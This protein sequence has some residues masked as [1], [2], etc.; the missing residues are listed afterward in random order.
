MR[1]PW[2][3]RW[4]KVRPRASADASQRL[5][6]ETLQRTLLLAQKFVDQTKRES[7]AEAAAVVAQAE[8]T[9]RA[10]IA[11]AEATAA[12]LQ[13]ETHQK[14]R[15]E[16]SRLESDA[17]R[18]GDRRREHGPAPRVGAQ[19]LAWRALRDPQVG[20][21]ERPARQLA[22]GCE[23]KAGSGRQGLGGQGEWPA[24]RAPARSGRRCADAEPA[25]R[26]PAPQC[27]GPPDLSDPTRWSRQGMLPLIVAV[28][29]RHPLPGR[30]RRQGIRPRRVVRRRER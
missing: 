6:D 16:V 11:A 29:Y 13:A 12:Q 5:S 10:A 3:P 23:A 26:T 17:D 21:R 15:E 1:R 18:A 25:E 7:E 14:L 22:D 19:P 9:A 24:L 30:G 27:Q 20:R 4:T 8:E 28:R 2:R